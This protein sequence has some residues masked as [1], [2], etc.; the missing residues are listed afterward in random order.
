MSIVEKQ[1]AVKVT[2]VGV[3]RSLAWRIAHASSLEELNVLLDEGHTYR[4]P[5]HKTIKRWHKE[6]AI[7]AAALL[8][9]GQGAITH[10]K[11]EP[12]GDAD[13]GDEAVS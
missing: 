9:A 13:P 3:T 7:R 4:H 2:G 5:S 10:E 12:S 8:E 11:S 1:E 6:A